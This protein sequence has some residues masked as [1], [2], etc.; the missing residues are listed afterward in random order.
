MGANITVSL[1]IAVLSKFLLAIITSV[2]LD[3]EMHGAIVS[4][5]HVLWIATPEHFVARGTLY[6]A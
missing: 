6:F 3:P 5:V 4:L 1:P 2:R